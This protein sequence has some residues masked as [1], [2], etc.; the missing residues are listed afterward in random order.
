MLRSN[1]KNLA[2]KKKQHRDKYLKQQPVITALYK[3]K[4]RL[5]R[6]LTRKH[7][8]ARQCRRLLPIFLKMLKQIK[9]N[10]YN[11]LQTL[12]KTLHNWREEIV[13]RWSNGITEGFHRKMKLF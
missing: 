2:D 13:Q 10:P 11:P 8:T 3:F 6:F 4:Q 12:A 1:L 5:H 9:R 7:C